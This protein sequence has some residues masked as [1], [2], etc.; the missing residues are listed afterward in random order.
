[1]ST[2]TPL[3]DRP[4]GTSPQ[5]AEPNSGEPLFAHYTKK[6]DLTDAYVFGTE[7]EALCGYRWVPTRNPDNYPVCPECEQLMELLRAMDGA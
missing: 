6:N 7:K 2:A 4:T 3:L 1:M 5:P